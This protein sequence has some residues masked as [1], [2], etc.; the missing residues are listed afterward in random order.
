MAQKGAPKAAT[1]NKPVDA[2]DEVDDQQDQHQKGAQGQA[3]KDMA[4]VSGFYE[5]RAGENVDAGKLGQAVNQ[6]SDLSKKTKAQATARDKELDKVVVAKDDVDLVVS[7]TASHYLAHFTEATPFVYENSKASEFDIAPKR[8]ERLL[9]ESKG[10]VL[11]AIGVL[12]TV[13]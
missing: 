9:R 1:S 6:I 7:T 5:E 12:L 4:N 2:S 8:A 13:S 10:D 11:Q 3:T